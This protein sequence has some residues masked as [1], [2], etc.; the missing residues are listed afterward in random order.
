[1]SASEYAIVR[2][3]REC[4]KPGVFSGEDETAGGV[5]LHRT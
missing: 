5:A 4:C 2:L 3:A 1:M